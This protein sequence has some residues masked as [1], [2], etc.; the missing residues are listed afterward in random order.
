MTASMGKK[1]GIASLIMMMSVL[2][3]RFI[4]LLREMVIAS[5]GGASTM[6]DAYQAAFLVP[7]ILNHLVA[8]GFLSVTFIPIFT[9]YLSRGREEDG[10]HTFSLILTT[11]GAMLLVLMA[12]A[13]L[14]APYLIDILAAGRDDPLFTTLAVRMTRIIIPAQFFFFS[15]GLFMAVQ[16][17]HGH[18]SFPAL[19]PLVY[20]IGIILGGILLGRRIGVEG[21]S[22]GVLAGAFAGNFL[23]QLWAARRV[24][25]RYRPLV[26]LRHPDLRKYVF[27]TLPL[28]VGLTMMFSI[29]IFIRFFGSFLPEGGIA[30]L[31]YGRTV[32]LIPVGLFGQAVGVA[33]FPFMARLV[34]EHRLAEMNQ[35]LNRTLR[36]L[37]LVMP[38]SVLMMVLRHEMVRILF[39]RGRFDA[40]AAA[41]T[42]EVLIYMLPGAFALSAYTVVVRGFHA[43]QNTMF[44]AVFGTIAVSLSLP[45][46][47]FGTIHLG[48]GGTAA[49]VSLSSI[50][51][52]ALLYALWNRRSH[53]RQS[54]AVY[55]FYAKIACISLAVGFL[56][57]SVRRTLID[58]APLGDGFWSSIWISLAVGAAFVGVMTLAA[59]LFRIQEV[60]DVGGK[61]LGRLRRRT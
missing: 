55:R 10:W 45:L 47:W 37:A 21:F 36:Y 1:I 11:F 41:L 32:L 33:S 24:G 27:L 14:L 7:E 46:Y 52:V 6:V 5:F 43:M 13:F 60:T 30:A 38:I 4:G 59:V 61:L 20:N 40:D 29:E 48:A 58:M 19:A 9:G 23:L 18:F 8:S 34:A 16:F 2:A 12:A 57:E 26:D 17:A 54:G 49:A 15:G 3:S 35:L 44:P 39:Q 50:L 28:M 31:N 53:N 56:L 42:V 22:W 25:M 51:Q